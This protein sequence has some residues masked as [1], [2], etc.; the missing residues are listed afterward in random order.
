MS[1]PTRLSAEAQVVADELVLLRNLGMRR[2]RASWTMVLDRQASIAAVLER[3]R[4]KGKGGE[5]G[6]GSRTANAPFGLGAK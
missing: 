2:R 6:L 3:S 5:P 4:S 1:R